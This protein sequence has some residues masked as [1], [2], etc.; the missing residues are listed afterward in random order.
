M[1]KGKHDP[2]AYLSHSIFN[3]RYSKLEYKMNKTMVEE[4]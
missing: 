2:N 4:W 3:P 1:Q